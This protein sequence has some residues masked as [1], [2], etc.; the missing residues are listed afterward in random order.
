MSKSS[1]SD[2][3]GSFTSPLADVEM[4]NPKG[5]SFTTLLG[6]LLSPRWGENR[7]IQGISLSSLISL[8]LFRSLA[9]RLR[10]ASKCQI[11]LFL[12]LSSFR[13][14]AGRP[15]GAPVFFLSL[16]LPLSAGELVP[17][18]REGRSEASYSFATCI[19]CGAFSTVFTALLRYQAFC[20]IFLLSFFG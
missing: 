2:H 18:C 16:S 3:S 8:F 7:R 12:L 19:R 5:I 6:P 11:P 1:F 9:K 14:V 20:F 4:K 15:G 13:R 17:I 10:G